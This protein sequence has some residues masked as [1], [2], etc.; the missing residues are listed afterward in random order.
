MIKCYFGLPGCGKTTILTAIAQREIKKNDINMFTQIF[1][2][3][4]V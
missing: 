4:V 2:V 3:T 1:I